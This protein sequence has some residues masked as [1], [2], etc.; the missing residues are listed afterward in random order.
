MDVD[1]KSGDLNVSVCL[2][3]IGWKDG[4]PNKGTLNYA[5]DDEWIKDKLAKFAKLEMD[6][7]IR[8]RYSDKRHKV[9]KAMKELFSQA[10]TIEIVEAAFVETK[11]LFVD[12]VQGTPN[13][14]TVPGRKIEL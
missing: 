14:S 5:L 9:K 1:F 3:A 13:L 12:L 6:T 10:E 8:N 7:R 4:Q 2:A 11:Q